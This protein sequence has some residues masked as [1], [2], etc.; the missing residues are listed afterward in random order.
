MQK[1]KLSSLLSLVV[2]SLSLSSCLQDEF[3]EINSSPFL[4]QD[5]FEI[6]DVE[7]IPESV[8][9]KRV[10]IT[11]ETPIDDN[12]DPAEIA[13][14]NIGVRFGNIDTSFPADRDFFVSTPYDVGDQ[15]CF[16]IR[17]ERSDEQKTPFVNFCY[18]VE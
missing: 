13:S 2:L 18:L 6:T 14:N 5:F 3:P 16:D 1:L 11:F 4:A 9:R 12:L 10:R 7:F 8:T 17:Y 15:F